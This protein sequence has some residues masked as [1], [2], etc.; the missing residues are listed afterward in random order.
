MENCKYC[1]Q[2]LPEGS[3]VCPS[4]GRR[5]ADEET[6]V[7]ESQ[8]PAQETAPEEAPEEAP[9]A[10]EPK[11]KATPGKIALAVGAVVVLAAIL[12]ALI[13]A[14][15]K[16]NRAE[17]APADTAPDTAPAA[18]EATVPPTVPDD[19]NP[20]D[21]TCKGTYT[22]TDDQA[23]ADRN[24]VVATIGSHQL[25]NGQ[26]QVHYWST[27]NGLLT[28][29]QGYYLMMSGGLNYDQPLDVQRSIL[30]EGK[31]W[32]QL[33]LQQSLNNWQTSVALAAEAEK[34][35]IQM[36]PEEREFL[37]GIGDYLTAA[38][39]TN[40]MT[41]EELLK[42]NVGP[43]ADA[44][45]FADYQELYSR[46]SGYYA[47]EVDKLQPTAEELRAFYEEHAQEYAAGGL[48]EDSTMVNVRHILVTVKGEDGAAEYTEE[49]WKACE[50]EAQFILDTWL[51]GARTEES[52]A[53][54]AN[55]KSEDP[56]SNTAG[57]LYENVFQGQMVEPFDS[58]C[59][60]ESR[61]YG[62]YGLVKTDYG[63]HVM[64]FVSSTPQWQ[65]YAEKDWRT[66]QVNNL[67]KALNESYPMEVDYSKITL[68]LL[69]AAE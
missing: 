19:G 24:T 35:G 3:S 52:F 38:A 43:G 8:E 67:V 50:T 58:W 41:V 65:Y 22:V 39:Q 26:L 59:F 2:E 37:D 45:D 16:G 34:A 46:G 63:Y 23:L 12:A 44:Q 54:L 64:F 10:E 21:V 14:G 15:V 27:V 48:Q 56:G 40:N 68:G 17:E 47:Q 9:A 25:T 53:A 62:D 36:T 32:Q 69:A 7:T 11:K 18:T 55:E 1:N 60:D 28:S 33:L 31:T 6:P 49:D 66:E 20:D 29:Q 57:G 4:C 5:V 61:A 30:D 13:V 42:A 51:D